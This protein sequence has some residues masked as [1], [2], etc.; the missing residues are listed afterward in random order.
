MILVRKIHIRNTPK[1]GKRTRREN[2][3]F[4]GKS[5]SSGTYYLP[6][7]VKLINYNLFMMRLNESFIRTNS[8][9]AVHIFLLQILTKGIYVFRINKFS[10]KMFFL[11][12]HLNEV[13]I[14]MKN[15][16]IYFHHHWLYRKCIL[17]YIISNLDTTN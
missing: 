9:P 16:N 5:S 11:Y 4:R 3:Y 10:T 13:Y 17:N 2:K 1:K 8:K 7:F 14:R 6:T 12:S 15:L